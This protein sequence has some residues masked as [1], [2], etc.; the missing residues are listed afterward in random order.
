MSEVDSSN[1]VVRKAVLIGINYIN[2]TYARLY[3]CINDAV[4]TKYF[5]QDAFGYKESDIVVMRDDNYEDAIKPTLGNIVEQLNKL[6]DQSEDCEEIWVHYS[7]HGTQVADNNGDE[8]DGKDEVIVPCD[9]R[10]SGILRDDVL[11]AILS[12]SKCRTYIVMDCCN[13]GSSIDLPY[14]FDL[15]DGTINTRIVN[16]SA[17]DNKVFTSKQE[18]YMISGARDTQTAADGW[19]YETRVSMGACTQAFIETLREYNHH[20]SLE[21]LIKQLH[22]WMEV[23]NFTQRP[24]LSSSLVDGIKHV[25]SKT[26]NKTCS[27]CEKQ[28][29]ENIVA[30]YENKELTE[31]VS[32]LQSL[33]NYYTIEKTT[34]RKKTRSQRGRFTSTQINELVRAKNEGKEWKDVNKNIRST[35]KADM[36]VNR[37]KAVEPKV[38]AVKPV[39]Q[40]PRRLVRPQK[41][42]KQRM[43]MLR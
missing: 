22:K 8:V 25:I 31:R 16:Q 32:Q 3:G 19:N 27:D 26:K 34:K 11:F 6:V 1:K 36:R 18:I 2:D 29:Q 4:Q 12:K 33:V 24:N 30:W 23:R 41:R 10:E 43:F 5:L 14:L 35:L 42:N 7:G 39:K 17:I 20:I 28:K 21:D 38:E 9:Y 13:S 40:P 37:R 15:K